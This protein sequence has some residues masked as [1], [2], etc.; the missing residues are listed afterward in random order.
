MLIKPALHAA[1]LAAAASFI[2]F[3]ANASCGWGDVNLQNAQAAVVT[4]AKLHFVKHADA[5]NHCPSDGKECQAKAYLIRGDVV[6]AG[7]REGDFVCTGYVTARGDMLLEW[8]PAASLEIAPAEAQKP[9][10][11]TGT[12][13]VFDNEI[14]IEPKGDA[15][16][17]DGNATWRAGDNVHVGDL[18]GVVKPENGLLA[19]TSTG[20]DAL[21]YAQGGPDD[22]RV[23]MAR[24]G[25]YLLVEDN[26]KCGGMNVTF[27]GFYRQSV[28]KQH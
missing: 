27:T 6:L 24:R 10:N 20:N 22:C 15:L 18:H 16:A 5:S 23:K 8:L 17:V 14:S 12:W 13:R 11:W 1:C 9:V 3:A 28:M 21:P 19:F 25:T 26:Y 4:P 2:P 7:T